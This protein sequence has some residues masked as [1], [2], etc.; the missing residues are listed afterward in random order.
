MRQ[1][2]MKK[3][4]K[5]K[6][7]MTLVEVLVATAI[8]AFCLSGLLLT[9]INLFVLTDI[10]RDSTV[11][12]SV[13]VSKLEELKS[14]SF[15]LLDNSTFN[16][17]SSGVQVNGRVCLYDVVD[18]VTNETYSNLKRARV[19]VSFT[20]RERTIGNSTSCGENV[21]GTSQLRS[22]IEGVIMI[23]NFTNS[24]LAN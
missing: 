18:P 12:N 15:W 7:G 19:I 22:P 20:S 3:N 8:F 13:L 23:N 6:K 17:I 1:K 5:N 24:T 4:R 9:Y 11:A 2:R 14:T 21:N 16:V 10:S